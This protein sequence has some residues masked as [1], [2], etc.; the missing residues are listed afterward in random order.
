MTGAMTGAWHTD[1][2]QLYTHTER[3]VRYSHASNYTW[4]GGKVLWA[5]D[6]AGRQ[7]DMQGE[8]TARWTRTRDPP[9][10]GGPSP[11]AKFDSV[12]FFL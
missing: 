3:G 12:T 6:R 8:S 7:G 2:V 11:Y 9:R 10:A 5:A 1:L 4:C